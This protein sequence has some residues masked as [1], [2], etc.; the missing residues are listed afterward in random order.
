[1]LRNRSAGINRCS[2]AELI[3]GKGKHANRSTWQKHGVCVCVCET[4]LADW[5]EEGTERQ[6][7]LTRFCGSGRTWAAVKHKERWGMQWQGGGGIWKKLRERDGKKYHYTKHLS[8]RR[9]SC[10]RT[11]NIVYAK[12]AACR[13]A[14]HWLYLQQAQVQ[15]NH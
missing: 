12:R 10:N 6:V 8:L 5:Q 1:M 9:L 11:N 2:E 3:K 4:W 14:E 13:G 7:I 15:I